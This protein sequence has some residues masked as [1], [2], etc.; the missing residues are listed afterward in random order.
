MKGDNANSIPLPTA[1][2][3]PGTTEID[4]ARDLKNSMGLLSAEYSSVK[5]PSGFVE[6]YNEDGTIWTKFFFGDL[7]AKHST[8]NALAPFRASSDGYLIFD[9]IGEGK[10]FYKVIA[11]EETGLVKYIRKDDPSFKRQRWQEYILS[12]FAVSALDKTN[13]VRIS[14]DG[15]H[16][17]EYLD[18]S[19]IQFEPLEIEGDWLKVKVNDNTDG[20]IKWRINGKLAISLFETA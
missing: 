18:R 9:L 8:D 1:S 13:S 17:K 19:Y 10:G 16:F 7:A 15:Q 3:V 12:C 14:P 5:I 11:N 20:W 2:P 6:I 4:P